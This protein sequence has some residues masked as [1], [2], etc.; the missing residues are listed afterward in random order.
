MTGL[1]SGLYT[2][3]VMHHR[4]RPRVHHLSY[5]IF[6]L[7]LDLDELPELDR[8]LR[9]FSAER[10]NLFSFRAADYGDRTGRDL[11]G[12]VEAHLTAAGLTPDGGRIRLLTMPRIL[13]YGFNPL[14]IF[15]CERAD[16]TPLALLY[17]VHNTFGERHG[18]LIPIDSA[19]GGLV[20]QQ[21][22]KGFYVSPFI[23]MDLAYD[24][25][26]RLPDERLTVSIN[27]GDDEGPLLAAVHTARRRDLSDRALIGAFLTHPL[28][29]LKVI[30]GIHVEA[31]R[32][33]MKGIRLRVRPAP[34]ADLV[35]YVPTPISTK[36]SK[37]HRS[38]QTRR[39]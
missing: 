29:T 26:L 3:T 33:W 16:G 5:R 39:A 20:R 31:L 27:V 24:F 35:T 10:F 7:L 21:C 23:D 22:G 32:I 9:L 15:Y 14:S 12:Q 30:G 34:P 37:G 36:V 11:K 1:S 8:R 38:W 28:L 25:R 2:G 19:A 6:S 18:Y 13:G 4:H 17:E